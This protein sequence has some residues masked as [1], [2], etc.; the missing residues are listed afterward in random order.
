MASRGITPSGVTGQPSPVNP[1]TLRSAARA[2][3]QQS[4]TPAQPNK[5]APK[6]ASIN[7]AKLHLKRENCLNT[8]TIIPNSAL[9]QSLLLIIKKHTK[10]A[11]PAFIT[12]LQAFGVILEDSL[13]ATARQAPV[14]DTFTLKLEEM[15][16]N[17]VQTGLSKIST[18]IQSSLTEQ[19][20]L[21]STAAALDAVANSLNKIA[22]DMNKSITDAN[23]A[24]SHFTVMADTYREV[25]LRSNVQPTTTPA[26]LTPPATT[27][28][29][30]E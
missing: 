30:H 17:T 22:S 21:Q 24:S 5:A 4:I 13:E 29:D 2:E 12:S 15:V 6:N 27:H 14:L 23:A 10:S 8:E 26:Q 16:E 9:I 19:N 18:T 28:S 11:S 20:K 3:V 1:R 25:L 7:E